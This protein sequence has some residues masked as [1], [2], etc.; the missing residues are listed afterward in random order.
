MC[1]VPVAVVYVV[2]VVA[3][4]YGHVSA[5]FTVHVLV[6]LVLLVPLWVALVGVVF[7][8]TVQVAVVCVVHV[9]A[10]R[11]GHVSASFAVRVAVTVMGAMLR[12]CHGAQLQSVCSLLQREPAL[13]SQA[14]RAK[15][16]KVVPRKRVTRITRKQELA[17]VSA[18]R[19]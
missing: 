13:T 14:K 3:V 4:R 19:Q 10:V 6:A 5:P 2:H 12:C 18:V 1:G 9:V 17:F 15:P 11:Y 7:V 16:Y 8:R